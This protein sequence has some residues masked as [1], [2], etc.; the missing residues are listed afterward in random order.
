MGLYTLFNS[1]PTE[2]VKA[3]SETTSSLSSLFPQQPSSDIPTTALSLLDH[4]RILGVSGPDATRFLQGQLTCDVES[5]AAGTSTLGARCNPKGRMLSSFRVL[6]LDDDNYLLA[7]ARDLLDAQ[8]TD[9]AKYAVFFKVELSDASDQWLRL[10]LWGAH[11]AQ[12][13][14]AASLSEQLTDSGIALTVGESTLELWLPHNNAN[15]LITALTQHAQPTSNHAWT[16]QQIR[17][18]IGHVQLE[19]RESFIPQMLNLDLI[20]GVSFTKGC[21]TGQEIV[22]RMHYLGKLKRRMYRLTWASDNL[23]LPGTVIV[24]SATD[25]ALGH[26]VVAAQAG[27]HIELLAVLQSDATQLPTLAISNSI[28]PPLQISTIP[29]EH[30]FAA[31]AETE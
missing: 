27:Q 18:G 16:L 3:M 8:Q 22:A 24:D 26:V 15:P 14:T 2:S 12:A 30:L 25:K 31:D 9:L 1:H 7:M 19:T 21:Y 28:E 4:D 20:G 11:A 5:L 6:K 10:G 23:P 17:A 29:Y 13:L